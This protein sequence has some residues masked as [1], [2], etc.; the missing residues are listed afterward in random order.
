M[1]DRTYNALWTECIEKAGIDILNAFPQK[2]REVYNW[3]CDFS[4]E[5]Q[6]EVFKRYLECHD[7]LRG[8]YFY[9]QSNPVKLIDFHKVGA[10]FA[11]AIIDSSLM[12]FDKHEN[13]P[14]FI[15]C[16]NYAL[17]FKA[18]VNMMIFF[19]QGS[20]YRYAKECYDL[21]IKQKEIIYPATTHGHDTY[22]IGRIKALALA[23]I[24]G[25]GFDYLGY[26]DM[27]YWIEHYNRQIIE[28]A[29]NVKPFIPRGDMS[30]KLN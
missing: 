9:G 19:L 29:I 21:L 8:S 18:S 26:A 13:L 10:C 15:A 3:N 6:K 24:N 27:L 2:K 11:K 20:Y 14:W 12:S 5:K 4:E 17:A 30:G 22:S 25:D 16:S 7:L 1:K 28:N 23:D